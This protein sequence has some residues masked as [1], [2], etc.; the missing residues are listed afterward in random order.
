VFAAE[1]SAAAG[2]LDRDLVDRHRL[3]LG[4]L[5]LP[6]PY[7]AES[8]PDLLAAM[9]LDKKARGATLRFVVLEGLGSPF[10]LEGPDPA[11]LESAYEK[12]AA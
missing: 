8:W 1:L 6:T 3:V 4:S 12:V 5:G 11:L 9:R 7:R 10:I 2:L